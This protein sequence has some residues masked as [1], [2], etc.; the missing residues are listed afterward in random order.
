M[1]VLIYGTSKGKPTKITLYNTTCQ[2]VL[3][4]IGPSNIWCIFYVSENL[5]K[6][7]FCAFIE[8]S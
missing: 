5:S 2:T 1:P 8:H 4:L 6:C 7:K 3:Y